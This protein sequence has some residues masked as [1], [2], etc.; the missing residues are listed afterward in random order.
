MF[1]EYSIPAETSEVKLD[2]DLAKCDVESAEAGRA[3]GTAGAVLLVTGVIAW[4]LAVVGLVQLQ[5]SVLH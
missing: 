5:T 1:D 3:L 4:P 2:D